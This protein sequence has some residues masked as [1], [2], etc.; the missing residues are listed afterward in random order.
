MEYI[1]M[2]VTHILKVCE[3]VAADGLPPLSFETLQGSAAYLLKLCTIYSSAIEQFI[4]RFV[5]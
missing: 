4:E 3:A 5:G 1:I 2:F